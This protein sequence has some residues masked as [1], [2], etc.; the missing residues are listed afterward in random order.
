MLLGFSVAVALV[1]VFTVASAFHRTDLEDYGFPTALGDQNWFQLGSLPEPH[2]LGKPLFT[3]RGR[4]L[5]QRKRKPLRYSDKL[6]LKADREDSGQYYLYRYNGNS[7]KN[8]EDPLAAGV[9]YIKTGSDQYIRVGN[10]RL[11]PGNNAKGK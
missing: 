10:V 7:G 1:S 11:T 5:Y 6:M 9:Y 8:R 2:D 4:E 3:Y